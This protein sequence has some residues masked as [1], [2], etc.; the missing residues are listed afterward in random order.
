M[1]KTTALPPGRGAIQCQYP[2]YRYKTVEY[3]PIGFKVT[4]EFYFQVTPINSGD[5]T[6]KSGDGEDDDD[7]ALNAKDA[8]TRAASLG[9]GKRR[10]KSIIGTGLE[11]TKFKHFKSFVESKILSKSDRSLAGDGDDCHG[12]LS[13]S[14]DPVKSVTPTPHSSSGG[15]KGSATLTAVLAR[16]KFIRR[17]SRTSF[18]DLEGSAVRLMSRDVVEM[19]FL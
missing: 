14:A 3:S 8:F 4:K 13:S 11:V 9:A 1:T 16:D 15:R 17:F 18:T 12:G 2:R 19:M 10:K 7:E 6:K 5:D